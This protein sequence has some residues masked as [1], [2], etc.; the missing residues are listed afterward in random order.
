M[1]GNQI[2]RPLY[3]IGLACPLRHSARTPGPESQRSIGRIEEQLRGKVFAV[4]MSEEGYARD[5]GKKAQSYLQLAWKQR[6]LL[7]KGIT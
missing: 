1:R 7:K 6:F 3:S 5:L 4:S 2:P